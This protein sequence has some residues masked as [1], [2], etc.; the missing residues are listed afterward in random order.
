[1]IQLFIFFSSFWLTTNYLVDNGQKK[2][3]ITLAIICSAVNFCPGPITVT[4]QTH[5][6]QTT[7]PEPSCCWV[8]TN[9]VRITRN[10]VGGATRS[11][12][13][14]LRTSTGGLA[15]CCTALA[16]MTS[17]CFAFL[18]DCPAPAVSATGS[19]LF[20]GARTFSDPTCS[21]PKWSLAGM[22]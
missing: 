9:S 22:T 5:R 12:A 21:V 11:F 15:R 20:F 1:A 3:Q 10:T 6:S 2:T 4:C 7:G 18:K 17:A 13:R 8:C 16:G 19:A 14:L